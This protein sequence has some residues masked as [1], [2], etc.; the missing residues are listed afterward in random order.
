MSGQRMWACQLNIRFGGSEDV[1][2]VLAVAWQWVKD[3]KLPCTVRDVTARYEQALPVIRNTVSDLHAVPKIAPV[4]QS[5]IISREAVPGFYVYF[6]IGGG[7]VDGVAFNFVNSGSE[8]RI[9]FYS[10]K[11]A[12]IGISAIA[13]AIGWSEQGPVDAKL[14]E[15]ELGRRA[16]AVREAQAHN[17]GSLVADVVVTAKRKD[18]RNWQRDIFQYHDRPAKRLGRLKPSEMRTLM[19]SSVAA[20]HSPPGIARPSRQPMNNFSTRTQAFR[21]INSSR[22]PS[23][24]TSTCTDYR[25]R[26]FGGSLS[27][28]ACPFRLAKGRTSPFP[29]K[30]PRPKKPKLMETPGRARRRLQQGRLLI[31]RECRL[32]SCLL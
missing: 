25:M 6:D 9:N 15:Q 26:S 24:K 16:K 32:A 17:V 3:G 10:G 18:G 20:G 21:P 11:V 19:Y 7:T 22:C 13:E 30:S 14:L 31:A 2:E 1:E 12:P 8:K 28:T 29:V 4:V 5:F 27:A 23:P